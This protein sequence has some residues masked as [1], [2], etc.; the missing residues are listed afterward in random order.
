MKAKPVLDRQIFLREVELFQ[1]L[2]SD[3]VEAL[4]ERMPLKEVEAGTVFY[5]PQQPTEVLFRIKSGRV[6]LYH[7]LLTMSFVMPTLW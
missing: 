3:E 4:G 6:R 2:T 1:D 5:S 7:L